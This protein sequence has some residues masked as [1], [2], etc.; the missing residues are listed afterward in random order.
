[1]IKINWDIFDANHG[2]NLKFKQY[3]WLG[4]RF[5]GIRAHNK[6]INARS[7][8]PTSR[9]VKVGEQARKEK[10]N[11]YLEHAQTH[12]IREA[13]AR[14]QFNDT[15]NAN[16]CS[17]EK[18]DVDD[19][20]AKQEILET[21]EASY[22]LNNDGFNI[23]DSVEI[24][25]Y[26]SNDNC[27]LVCQKGD[28]QWLNQVRCLGRPIY[29]KEKN[30][31]YI[32]NANELAKKSEK[33]VKHQLDFDVLLTLI[34]YGDYWHFDKKERKLIKKNKLEKQSQ[35]NVTDVKNN[36]KINNNDDKTNVSDNNNDDVEMRA[37]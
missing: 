13:G 7:Y 18:V 1:M 36:D 26:Y 14:R 3:Q 19:S 4:K 6:N 34:D 16:N 28:Y 23:G 15:E 9:R 24:L 31:Q 5:A 32:N 11:N 12:A 30:G 22:D 29:V 37:L 20:D 21:R 8:R 33:K 27:S 10:E 35:S 17:D 25:D 2:K